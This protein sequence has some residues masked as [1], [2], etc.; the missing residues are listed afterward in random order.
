[1]CAI[2]WKK[3]AHV[4]IVSLLPF[5][6]MFAG[7]EVKEK[8]SVAGNTSKVMFTIVTNINRTVNGRPNPKISGLEFEKI[9]LVVWQHFRT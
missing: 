2:G 8:V 4:C 9:N 5:E 3:L 6:V 1:M 7:F